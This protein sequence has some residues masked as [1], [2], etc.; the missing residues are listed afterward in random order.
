MSALKTILATATSF[1]STLGLRPIWSTKNTEGQPATLGKE[2]EEIINGNF[3][4]L[5]TEVEK[6]SYETTSN[7]RVIRTSDITVPDRSSFETINIVYQVGYYW[8]VNGIRV[9]HNENTEATQKLPITPNVLTQIVSAAS[10]N[11]SVMSVVLFNKSGALLSVTSQSFDEIIDNETIGY[12]ALS[13]YRDITTGEP[14]TPQGVSQTTQ[15]IEGFE[16]YE[17]KF[18]GLDTALSIPDR[19]SFES[20]SLRYDVGYFYNYLGNKVA[21]NTGVEATNKIRIEDIPDTRIFSQAGH[22]SLYT[23][24]LFDKSGSLLSARQSAVNEDVDK[25]TVG[26][27]AFSRFRDAATGEPQQQQ[28]LEVTTESTFGGLERYEPMFHSFNASDVSSQNVIMCDGDSLTMGFGGNGVTYPSELQMLLGSDFRVVNRGVG[29]EPIATIAARTGAFAMLLSNPLVLPVDT[30]KVKIGSYSYSSTEALLT[31]D[32]GLISSYDSQDFIRLLIQGGGSDINPI[33]ING[34]ECTLSH[35]VTD[36]GGVMSGDY[37]ISRN[38][39]G[40]EI[41]IPTLTPVYPISLSHKAR[42]RIIFAGTNG[43]FTDALDYVNQM[44]VIERSNPNQV[45]LFIGMHKYTSLSLL[46]E[47]EG[48]MTKEFGNRFVNNRLY[49]STNA[50][51]DLGLTPTAQDITD[52]ANGEAPLSLLRSSGDRIHFNAN[53]YRAV[54]LNVYNTIKKML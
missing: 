40:A 8:N 44:K 21:H 45:F 12:Y 49:L 52:M 54:A 14:L 27:V 18:G 33:S 34:I 15:R 36:V 5:E 9:V 11:N 41:T 42:Y 53:G 32:S 24:V 6:K 13:R 46:Q 39:A 48:L 38:T 1:V 37:Y 50:M 30:T 17:N 20:V 43:R 28:R 7:G 31:T 23:V 25:S 10:V 29:G 47:I 35:V 4:I 3:T 26:F 16:R 22:D 51:A 19:N 2:A